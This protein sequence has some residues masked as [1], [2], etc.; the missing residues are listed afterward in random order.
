MCGCL[1]SFWYYTARRPCSSV[2][3]LRTLVRVMYQ[4]SDTVCKDC[5]VARNA[6]GSGWPS[7][8]PRTLD[9]IEWYNSV[10]NKTHHGLQD[11]TPIS[12]LLAI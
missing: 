2:S 10:V 12:P 3:A 9:Y 6:S 7:T 8:P 1:W 5:N 11:L 4:N